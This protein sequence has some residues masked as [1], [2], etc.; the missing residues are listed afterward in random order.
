MRLDVYIHNV[1][2]QD[3]VKNLVKK[4]ERR[5]DAMSQVE[6]QLKDA[7]TKLNDE[8]TKIGNRLDQLATQ[9]ANGVTPEVG[10]QIAQ[11]LNALGDKLDVMAADPNNPVPSPIQ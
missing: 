2:A 8:T 9:V 11:E 10:A 1:E 7:V 3:D 5:M 4:L 6:Q